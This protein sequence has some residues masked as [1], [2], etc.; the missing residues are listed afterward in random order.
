MKNPLIKEEIYQTLGYGQCIKPAT[1]LGHKNE[2]VSSKS[3]PLKKGEDDTM[4]RNLGQHIWEHP[5]QG[6][7]VPQARRCGRCGHGWS[8]GRGRFTSLGISDAWSHQFIPEGNSLTLKENYWKQKPDWAEQ[9]HCEWVKENDYMVGEEGPSGKR[10]RNIPQYDTW[11][12]TCAGRLG[13]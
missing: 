3:S 11:N 5:V 9:K 4:N 10:S 8:K 2:K 6:R 12:T 1:R 13:L 7:K